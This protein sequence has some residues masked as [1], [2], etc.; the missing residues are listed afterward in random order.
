MSV[1]HAIIGADCTGAAG[2]MPQYPWH[3]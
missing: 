3:N 1:I 2:K